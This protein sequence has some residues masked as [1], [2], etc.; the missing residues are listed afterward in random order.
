MSPAT[1]SGLWI[2]PVKSCRGVAVKEMQIGPTGPM[3]DREWM[4]VDQ[5]N[6]FLTLRNVAELSQIK[7]ALQGPFLHLYLG[8]NKILI[9]TR[10]ES[11]QIETVTVWKDS[12]LVGVATKDIN[13][14]LSDF[15]CKTVKLVRYQ[16]QSFRDLGAAGTA[17]V[18]QVKFAD[19]RPVLLTSED[20]LKELNT[21]LN[22]QGL[23][24]IHI[25][26]FRS[27][28]IISGLPAYA[29]DKF[30]KIKAGEITLQNPRLCTR[31]VVITQD[32]E[33]GKVTS[34]NILKILA[35]T[36]QVEGSKVTFGLNLT[37]QNLGTIRLNDKVQI[38]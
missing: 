28:I 22:A 13:E 9:D 16:K 14:A 29:E 15:L 33:N 27:N 35:N 23:A 7:T 6:N 10:I 37:P 3:H 19:S 31:C 38:L 25:E 32:V 5:D 2:Y 8:N 1:V 11:E 4:I 18:K 12:F 26:R 21:H 17:A 30:E 36:H 34:K 20:S 24:P